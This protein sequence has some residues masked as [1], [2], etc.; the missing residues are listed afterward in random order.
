MIKSK[1]DYELENIWR[2]LLLRIGD[3]PNR[4]GLEDT[5][6]RIMKMYKELFRGYD[7]SQKPK[8]TTFDNGSD[9]IVCDEMITDEGD[10]Y[11]MCEHHVMPFTGR[12]HFAYIAHPKG[13]I[14]GLS[15]VARVVDFFS[16]KLQIQERL[17]QDIVNYIYE[18]LCKGTR[19]KPL[20]VA[21][22]ME[23]EHL[24]K[25]M[26]GVKKKGRMTTKVLKGVF[27][28]D[29]STREEFLSLIK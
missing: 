14:L 25:T 23:A 8:V 22:F 6:E 21:L 29:T 28:T 19:Y 9:G 27:K 2:E 11:S 12:Y 15:K 10:F 16:A 17:T 7:K 20:G 18:E 13:K 4:E 5:P 26:R 3:D 24:C 1:Y